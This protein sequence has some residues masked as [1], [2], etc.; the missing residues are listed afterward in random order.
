MDYWTTRSDKIFEEP[1]PN[2]PYFKSVYDFAKAW[3]QGQKT[4]LLTTSG[5]TGTPKEIA[6]NREQMIAS[7][8]LTGQA[9]DLPQGTRAL[10][11]LNVN[12]IAGI[13]ML[14]RGLELDWQ[15]TI[16]NPGS[17]PLLDVPEAICFDFVALVPLQL[18]AILR[19]ESTRGR[20]GDLGKILLGGAPLS[21]I[22]S[23][24]VRG[25]KIPVYQSYGMTETVSHVALR[26]VNGPASQE[27][28]QVLPGV[29]FGV[30]DRGC[31]HLRGAVTN[32]ER[33]Q[34]N[35]LVTITS[36][37]SFHW[38]GRADS[39]INSGGVKISLDKMDQMVGKVLQEMEQIADYFS[40]H[41]PDETLGQKLVLFLEGSHSFLGVET[42]LEKI[43]DRAKRYE[44]PKAVYFVENFIR[45]PTAKIDKSATAQYH[46]N[47]A[48]D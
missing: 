37:N 4:F 41:E 46:F 43:S 38:L 9:L 10:V 40:W 2:D 7:A 16:V 20:V 32:K 34:T 11:C 25:L 47:P 29:E 28:F 15:L 27:N 19:D 18:T 24:E 3:L 17:N 12:Y 23:R 44:T 30:D 6:L 35:D 39:V 31:L 42:L 13:M 8:H 26:R 45:T 5:S 48:H 22:L 21:E 33:L 36:P 14:V 1:I